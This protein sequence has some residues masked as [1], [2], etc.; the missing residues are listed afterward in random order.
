MFFDGFVSSCEVSMRKPDPA[1][2]KLAYGY[3]TWPTAGMRLF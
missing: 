2:F 1:I 3:S